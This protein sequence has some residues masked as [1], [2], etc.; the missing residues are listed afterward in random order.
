M[1]HRLLNDRTVLERAG[2]GRRDDRGSRTGL[3]DSCKSVFP[4]CGNQLDIERSI[5]VLGH[6]Y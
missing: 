4:L 3:T 5:A 6:T 2:L 1:I